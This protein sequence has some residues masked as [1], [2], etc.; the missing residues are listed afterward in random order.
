MPLNG[1]A[2]ARVADRVFNYLA[3]DEAFK[4]QPI[5]A[6]G[7]SVGEGFAFVHDFAIEAGS[8][9]DD[10]YQSDGDLTA[11]VQRQPDVAGR[12]RV[13]KLDPETKAY[14]PRDAEPWKVIEVDPYA[15]AGSAWPIKLRL[16][17]DAS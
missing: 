1:R 10:G 12:F 15:A 8:V 14:V 17:R 5:D 11:Y 9:T 6:K 7:R 16:V 4:L 13:M 3:G 2:F